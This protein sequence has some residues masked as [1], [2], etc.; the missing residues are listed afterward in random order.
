MVGRARLV[1]TG[2]LAGRVSR[3]PTATLVRTATRVGRMSLVGAG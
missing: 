2:S 3:V 1:S